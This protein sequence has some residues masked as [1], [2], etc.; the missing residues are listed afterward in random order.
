VVARSGAGTVAE[1]TALGKACILIP[2]PA[3]AADEQ[4]RTARHLA[5]RGAARMLDQPEDTPQN[6]RAEILSLLADGPG[7]AALAQ[8]AT[9]YGR[10][11]AA[12]RVVAEILASAAKGSG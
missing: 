1:L 8:A 9:A 3:S 5:E 11:D 4:R 6:L 12:D 2:Y 7:R 10:P